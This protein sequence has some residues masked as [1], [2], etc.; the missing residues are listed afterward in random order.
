MSPAWASRA[1]LPSSKAFI[2]DRPELIAWRKGRCLPYGE[3]ITFWA[4][5]EIVKA[6]AGILESDDPET[7]RE[8]LLRAIPESE[9]DRDWLLARV[10]TLV[11][12]DAP[13]AEREES[14][15]A[16]RRFLEQIAA[17]RPAVFVVEDLHWADPAMLEFLEHLGEWMQGLQVVIVATARPELFEHHP[18]WAGGMRNATTIALGPLSHDETAELVAAMLD[19]TLLPANVQAAILDRSGGNPLYA[20]EFVRMLKDR[21]L[22]VKSGGTWRL[23]ETDDIPFP[24]TV[25]ALIAARLDTLSSDHKAL[26]QDASVIGQVFWAEAVAEIRDL[27]PDE[28]RHVFHDLSRKELVKPV[29]SSSM[30]GQ[31]EYA[32]WHLLVRDVAYGQIPRT[33]RAAKHEAAAAWIETR[34]PDRLEDLADVLAHHYEQALAWSAASGQPL[35]EELAA[36]ARRFLVLAGEIGRWGSTWL[37]RPTCTGGPWI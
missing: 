4:L 15:T 25:Q 27:D 1:W 23:D 17:T 16:W 11:G 3:G 22:L 5:G 12:L 30:A 32:F 36:R 7:A 20:E 14:F 29:R 35:N 26:L 31:T 19:Q 13:P 6:E 9:P 33:A 2:H 37:G 21:G 8:K 24:D 10:G 28:V 18:N 34:S